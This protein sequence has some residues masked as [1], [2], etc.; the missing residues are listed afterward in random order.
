MVLL[1][2]AACSPAPPPMVQ[3]VAPP[4]AADP[5]LTLD[6]RLALL[7]SRQKIAQIVMPWIPGAYVAEDSPEFQRAIGWVRD[8]EVGGIIVSIGSPLDVAARVNALQ[9][10]THVPLL[11]ASDLESGTAFR[12]NGGTPFPSNMGIG[13]AGREADAYAM[14][15]ITAF[16]GRAVGIHLALAP[17]ADVNNNPANPIINTRSFGEDP[18]AV[19]RLVAAEIRG[20]EENG[21]PATAK[22]F[23]G[24]GDTGV[25]SHLALP[26]IAA[27]WPRLN[28]VELVPFRAAVAAGATAVMSA[29]IAL[30]ALDSTGRPSTLAPPILTGILRDSLGFGGLVVTDA[31]NMAGVTSTYGA[32][33]AAV[34]AFLAGADLLLQPADPAV[35]IEAMERA[36]AE[37][38]FDL[39]RLDRS[40]RRV[41]ALKER[42]GVFQQ[43]LVPLDSV[44]TVV[45][46][47]E[48]R[49]IAGEIARRA[50]VLVEDRGSVVDSLRARR[51]RRLLI[52][53]GDETSP[54]AGAA[55][56]NELRAR[57][58]TITV[59]R[60]RPESGAASYDSVFAAIAAR[61]KAVI[62]AIGIR[63]N[64]GRGTIG[65]P[66]A[67]GHLLEESAC[68]VPTVL[69]SLG[70]PYIRG[71]GSMV[72]SYL[73]AWAANSL[74][75][76]AVA[77]A[78]TGGAI[79][80]TLP[81][82]LPTDIP[83]GTGLQRP[84]LTLPQ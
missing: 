81:V 14:G 39:V 74:T 66:I 35:V 15:R 41:L 18:Q 8:L 62:F 49:S 63:A 5:G 17:V 52:T 69:V 27:E 2:A 12:L 3:P 22:H 72:G 65:I 75:E 68:A 16:E 31:L 60:L 33:E 30:P 55:L 73:I 11:I 20:L 44:M 61:P 84:P 77:D 82:S 21:M 43:R 6:Q 36:L 64:S 58:D 38:R 78:L 67:L 50:V 79:S 51:G 57:G 56:A 29:H 83:I 59:M 45:G 13:A 9:R 10:R 37:G 47:Q 70:S 25:D 54:T 42:M 48:Y 76:A 53:Y 23:P 1:S 80:G 71:P 28:A 46:K 4:S 7:T 24:H 34:L 32:G 40:V 26:V 19:A